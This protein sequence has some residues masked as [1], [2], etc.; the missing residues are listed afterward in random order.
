MFWQNIWTNWKP[1]QTLRN[2]GRWINEKGV[3]G[4][5][6]GGKFITKLV[7]G[8]HPVT[9]AYIKPFETG[10]NLIEDFHRLVNGKSVGNR[11]ESGEYDPD[12]PV[13]DF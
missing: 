4:L 10:L 8:L 7:G 12:P 1:L 3:P 13:E 9:D 11:N 5:L 2:V 6:T